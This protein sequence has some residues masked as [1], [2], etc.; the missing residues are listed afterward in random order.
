MDEANFMKEAQNLER[1][2]TQLQ[3]FPFVYVPKVFYSV[4]CQVNNK[5]IILLLK[6]NYWS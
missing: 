2:K 5:S 3:N 6:E 4:T 1:C